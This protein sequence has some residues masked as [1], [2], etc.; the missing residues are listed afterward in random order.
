MS[1]SVANDG[2]DQAQVVAFLSD[3]AT[4]GVS[5][6]VE[7]IDTH[8]AMIFL[9]GD[10][11]Y[12][13]KRAVR[14]PYLDFTTPAKRKA[15]CE[16]E[17][18]LNSRTAPELYLGV[19]PVGREPDGGLALGRGESL[20]WV[21]VMQRFAADCLFDDMAREHRLGLALVRDLADRIAAF[22][23]AAP[24]VAG[25]GAARVRAV[26]EGNRA[27]MAA[28]PAG[29]L[30]EADCNLLAERSLALLAQLAP[31]LDRR[32]ASGHVRHCHGDLH[33]ANICLWQGR[34]TL[35][36]C[37]EFNPELATTDVLYDVAFLLMDLSQRGL[38][39]EASLLFNRYCDMRGESD[40]LAAMPLF[41]AM[42]AAVR[43]HVEASAA[44][45][46]DGAAARNAK[47]AA[48]RHYLAAAL[49]FLDRPAPRL[50]A[51][52]GLSGTGKSTLAGQLAPLIGA[53]PGARWLRTD[54]LRKRIAGVAPEDRLP[55]ESY[56]PERNAI[57][58]EKVLEEARGVIDAG[59]S[60]VLD[61]VFAMAAERGAVM[62]L[63]RATGAPFSGLW[64]EAPRAVMRDRVAHRRGDASDADVAVI[65]RQLEYALGDMTGW[66]TVPAAGS[67]EDV[68]VRA[69]AAIGSSAPK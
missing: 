24:V 30:A 8:A 23:A 43:A 46:Q 40:G 29:I 44:G 27:S 14:Y 4:F 59:I 5:G 69:L 51:I 35:F 34:P 2:A 22:H 39:R 1:A 9:A 15:V 16:A 32:A 28:L 67:P 26:I 52:G 21:V 17:L 50:I 6:P 19:E 66:V 49:G 54:V 7:R 12:K 61:G 37:L 10:R 53:A 63:A 38:R 3:P 57:V 55:A 25:A 48:A 20:D 42:R 64:L 36:D 45:R 11:V 65:D 31:L 56:T 62:D 41:L 47:I 68:L 33:L 58:Y 18:A 13:L 60:L